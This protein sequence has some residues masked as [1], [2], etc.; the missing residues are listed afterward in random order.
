MQNTD[1]NN[2]QKRVISFHYTL[3][4]TK[5]EVLDSSNPGE[6]LPFLEG[7]GQILPALEARVVGMKIGEKTIVHLTANDGYG[8]FDETM[9]IDVPKEELAHIPQL[10]VGSHLRLEVGEEIRVVRVT[11][12]GENTIKLDGNHPLAGVDL[13][14][15]IELATMRTA[16]EEE[17]QH[18]HAHGPGVH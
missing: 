9:M 18:G 12:I 16:S 4:N 13:V 14:F 1:N 5:G 6:P 7:A 15:E 17:L 8:D 10:D 2:F 3:R 11:Q